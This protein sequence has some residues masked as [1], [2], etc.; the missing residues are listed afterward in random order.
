MKKS[1]LIAALFASVLSSLS[2][3]AIRNHHGN[4]DH[5]NGRDRDHH[6]RNY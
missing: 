6:Y 2:S 4:R 3:C 5:R 1:I